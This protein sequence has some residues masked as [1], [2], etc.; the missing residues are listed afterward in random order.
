MAARALGKDLQDQQGTVIDRHLQMAL[1]IALLGRAERLVEQNLGRAI[2][3]RHHADLIGFATAH[4]QCG[5]G[6]LA[7]AHQARHRVQAGRLRQQTQ[8][9][10]FGIEVRKTKIHPDQHDRGGFIV[11]GILL[12]TQ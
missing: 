2:G 8:L 9:F 3:L 6:H 7:L 10:E 5:I 1:Q 4:K 11:V 12:I